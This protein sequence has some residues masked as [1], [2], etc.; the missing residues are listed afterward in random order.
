MIQTI[1]PKATSHL[2]LQQERNLSGVVVYCSDGG[3]TGGLVGKGPNVKIGRGL[4]EKVFHWEK[5]SREAK[6]QGVNGDKGARFHRFNV[7][8]SIR[9]RHVDLKVSTISHSEIDVASFVDRSFVVTLY[10]VR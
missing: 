6:N 8:A 10:G 9:S 1:V 2:D 5:G 7:R 3:D 4:Q